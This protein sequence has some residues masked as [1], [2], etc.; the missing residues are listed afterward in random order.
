MPIRFRSSASGA[1]LIELLVIFALVGILATI[2]VPSFD[3]IKTNIRMAGEINTLLNTLNFARTEA[4]KRGQQVVVCPVSGNACALSKNWTTGWQ[5][6]QPDS[7][8]QL[9]SSPGVSNG[10]TLTSTLTTYPVFTPMGYTFF[11]GTLSLHESKN[12]PSLYRCIVFN[13]GSWTTQQGTACP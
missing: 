11:N 2:A 8:T 4:S 1:T 9:N 12:N 10:D 7:S 13:A 3:S 6:F 5:V